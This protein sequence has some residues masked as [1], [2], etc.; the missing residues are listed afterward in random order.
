MGNN[1]LSVNCS[2]RYNKIFFF[3]TIHKSNHQ[4]IKIQSSSPTKIPKSP[5][6]P[7]PQNQR[8]DQT[9]HFRS[10]STFIDIKHQK[11]RKHPDQ[12][13]MSQTSPT[14]KTKKSALFKQ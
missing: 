8:A 6:H 9:N 14:K 5:T 10:N 2:F 1:I 3:K 13:S 4:I 11:L 7:E 12:S